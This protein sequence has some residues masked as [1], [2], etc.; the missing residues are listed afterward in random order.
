MDIGTISS[1]YAKA[2]F[3]LAKEK[4]EEKRVYQDIR[5]LADSF[6]LEPELKGALI[7]P[8]VAGEEKYKLLIAAGG[9]EVCALYERFIRLVLSHKREYFLPFMAQIYIHLYRLEKKIVR[10]KFSTA[11]PV[12]NAV[13]EHLRNK[14]EKETGSTVEFSG[15]INPELIGGFRLC[16]GNYRID[17][18]YVTQLSDIRDRLLEK[19]KTTGI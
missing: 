1:R 10:V 18:S 7:N 9:I 16:I 4:K 8:V 3:S 2:L 6:S 19:N 15:H 13:K 5:M 12:G 11:V 17:A 14:L